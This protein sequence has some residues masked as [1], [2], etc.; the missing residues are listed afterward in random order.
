MIDDAHYISVGV[1]DC[2]S[3]FGV[4]QM[5]WGVCGSTLPYPHFCLFVNAVCC[6]AGPP[7]EW[8]LDLSADQPVNVADD[9]TQAQAFGVLMASWEEQQPGR[10]M[11][12]C[13]C[14]RVLCADACVCVCARARA[15]V[16][17]YVRVCVRVRGCQ[18]NSCGLPVKYLFV[19]MHTYRYA[20]SLS[21][22]HI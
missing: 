12:V 13:G 8:V 4:G 20:P 2:A 15:C 19:W 16:C 9:D 21:L 18:D 6:V 17:V 3:Q 22:I 10:A 14:V 11:L 5:G 1:I 7:L